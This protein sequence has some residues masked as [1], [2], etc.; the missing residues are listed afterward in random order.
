MRVLYDQK[1][2]RKTGENITKIQHSIKETTDMVLTKE[3]IW[4]FMHHKDFTRTGR[5][6]L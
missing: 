6:F 3:R 4:L 5:E 2:Q 1:E